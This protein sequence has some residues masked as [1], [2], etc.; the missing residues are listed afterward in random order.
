VRDSIAAWTKV[1]NFDRF[2]L[3]NIDRTVAV[4]QRQAAS[5]AVD[6]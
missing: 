2:D 1:M 3:L 4:V 5:A 6:I